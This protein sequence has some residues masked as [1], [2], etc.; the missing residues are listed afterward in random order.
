[1]DQKTII[2]Y[3][4]I[5]IRSE[6]NHV[7]ECI[8]YSLG[9]AATSVE[10]TYES[11]SDDLAVHSFGCIVCVH[12]FLLLDSEQFSYFAKLFSSFL[13]LLFLSLA[14]YVLFVAA[15][16]FGFVGFDSNLIDQRLE[17]TVSIWFHHNCI[18]STAY[19]SAQN[20]PCSNSPY[21]CNCKSHF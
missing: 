17:A 12:C 16:C 15:K 7:D 10:D 14:F 5:S 8:E 4:F 6:L 20:H 3:D 11:S 21:N 13:F 1:M 18:L 2:Q 19:E 9:V